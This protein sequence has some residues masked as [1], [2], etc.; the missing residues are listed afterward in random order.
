M[1]KVLVFAK[2]PN[3][4]LVSSPFVDWSAVADEYSH[5][6]FTVKH[7]VGMSTAKKLAI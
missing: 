4:R 7:Y 3:H 6:S 2:A 5:G 1:I